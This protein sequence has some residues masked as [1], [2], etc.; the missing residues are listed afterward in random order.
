MEPTKKVLTALLI[1]AAFIFSFTT[2][3]S[4]NKVVREISPFDQVKVSDDLKVVFK[5]AERKELPLL[6]PESVMIKLSQ[7]HQGES[8]R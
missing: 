2:I 8:S 4:Q 5:K 6:L 7:N 3:Y 1:F